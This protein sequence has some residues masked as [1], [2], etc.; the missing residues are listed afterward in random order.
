MAGLG[1]Q[2]FKKILLCFE[3]ASKHSR[4]RRAPGSI[5]EQALVFISKLECALWWFSPEVAAK[6]MMD[7][8]QLVRVQVVD[9][10]LHRVGVEQPVAN[11]SARLAYAMNPGFS[12]YFILWIPVGI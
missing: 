12:L 2:S 4:G 5:L 1:L 10:F 6:D 3:C 9:I 7:Q 8:I 11:A